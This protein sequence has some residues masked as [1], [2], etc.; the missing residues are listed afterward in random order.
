M[1]GICCRPDER[2]T[3]AELFELFKTPWEFCSPGGSYAI[4][5]STVGLAAC[6]PST[7]CLCF[8]SDPK[9][10]DRQNAI[11]TNATTTTILQWDDRELPVYG[12]ICT[13]SPHDAGLSLQTRETRESVTVNVP[14]T[15]RT[16][17]HFGFDLFQEVQHLL[18]VT[19]PPE[20][21]EH[22]ALD[23]H[24][25]LIRQS[26]LAAGIPLLEIPP[27]P[28]GHQ[29]AVCLTHD[30]DFPAIRPHRFDHTFLGFLVRTL[31]LSPVRYLRGT[32]SLKS[33]LHNYAALFS[34]PLVHMGIKRDFWSTFDEY[35]RLESPHPS[36]YYMIPFKACPGKAV[37]L[38]HAN[39]RAA[40][41]D[42][43]QLF[44]RV[45][46][47]QRSG[48][49][50]GLHAID[51]WHDPDA[52]RKERNR[53]ASLTGRNSLGTRTHWLC[54]APETPTILEA[55]GFD[56][57]SS[58]GYNDTIGY[59]AGS[60]QPFRPAAC[61]RLLSLPLHIQDVALF[62]PDGMV[63]AACDA[64]ARCEHLRLHALN[65]GG[66]LTILWH[67]RSIAPE[68]QWT[69]FYRYLISTLESDGAWFA[70][71][72]NV[73]AWFRRRRAVRFIGSPGI[74][75]SIAVQMDAHTHR[76]TVGSDATPSTRLPSMLLR[77]HQPTTTG[78][79]RYVDR[80][81]TGAESTSV[82][83]ATTGV[84]AEHE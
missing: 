48:R 44:E 76:A 64:R 39:R 65:H 78:T 15:L 31:F 46:S 51:A 74:K 84:C 61:D 63:Q 40:K 26:I 19:Q 68:R 59:R 2:P 7:P 62:G 36:T 20:T 29:Y 11:R 3:A 67:M 21:A 13:F 24:I 37:R 6:P 4:V 42:V 12:R 25:D 27:I 41:Y 32:L 16:T 17:R 69:E 56:Y 70:T 10:H 72:Q 22:P 54:S 53:I 35:D 18:T 52:A 55:A 1:I 79:H 58:M 38:P 5:L 73:V 9:H 8:S 83:T 14:S 45:S 71:A 23:T 49:E 81:W 60:T 50:V 30:V 77:L 47:L 82:N 43:A 66:A 28:E 34:L 33:L 75:G 57:D 80:A